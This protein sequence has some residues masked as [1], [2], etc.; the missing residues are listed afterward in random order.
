[1]ARLALGFF[2]ALLLNLAAIAGATAAEWQFV[3]V[4]GLV[5][6]VKANME[7]M[8]ATAGL[9]L[10][11]DATIAT[12]SRARAL[13]RHGEDIL[14]VGPSTQIAP[15]ARAVRGL[16]TVLMRQGTLD[17]DIERRGAPHFAVQTPVLAAVVK[18]TRFSVA[19]LGDNGAVSVD[20]GRVQVRALAAGQ[21]V[22][23]TNG[24][25]AKLSRRGLQVSGAG[26]HEPIQSV[27]PQTPM[28]ESVAQSDDTS[29]S[30]SGAS[31]NGKA[32]GKS[33]SNAGGNSSANA[34]ANSNAGGN[35]ANAGGGSNAGGNSAAH[36]NSNS[37]AGGNSANSNAGGNSANSNAGGNGKGKGHN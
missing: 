11:D 9:V 23:V 32:I 15:Q 21:E 26:A 5:W 35:S 33:A 22:D 20:T 17:L 34:A 7:P 4:T 36:A 14:N 16:T 2:F 27:A 8:R 29:G 1:M 18:G 28:V 6:V 30:A 24:Q 13:L 19:A 25:T 37:N 10:P 31:S 3:R 12:T